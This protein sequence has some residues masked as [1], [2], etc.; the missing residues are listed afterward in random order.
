MK[1]KFRIRRLWVILLLMT[2]YVSLFSQSLTKA[3]GT[4]KDAVTKEPVSFASVMFEGTTIGAMT[5]DDGAFSLQTTG[6]QTTL[7]IS[8]LGYQ[9]QK[10][11]LPKGK[12]NENLNILLHPTAYEIEEVTIRP[13][14][15]RYSRRDNPAVELIRKVIDNKDKNRVESEDMYKV[16][17]YEKLALALDDFDPNL[18]KNSLLKKFSFIKNYID[19]SVISGKPI[20]TLSV[21]E[22]LADRYYR[23]SPRTEKTITKGERV[24]GVD[25][26]IE[27]NGTWT[28]NL[29]EMIKGIDLYDNNIEILL[30][31]FVSPLSSTLAVSYYQY[32]IMDTLDVRGEPCVDLAFVPVNSESYGFTGRLYVTLDGNYSVKRCVLNVPR[33]INLNWVDFL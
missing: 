20:L 3:G 29:Q 28:A 4:V 23:K 18:E 15:E 1:N 13:T 22:K 5:D 11:A 6:D 26:T 12:T 27:D 24:E 19:T 31:R 7:S 17:V 2:G 33:H 25:K 30:N 9:T 10:L 14:R 8:S 32:Y 21:R 16:E